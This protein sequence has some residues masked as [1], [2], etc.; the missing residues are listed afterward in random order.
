MI[1]SSG[2]KSGDQV[3]EEDAAD[4]EEDEEEDEEDHVQSVSNLSLR[5]LR[6]SSGNHWEGGVFEHSTVL[7]D[8]N[9]AKSSNDE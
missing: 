2:E 3:M 7:D 8:D 4:E 1:K 9:D 6:T 5:L